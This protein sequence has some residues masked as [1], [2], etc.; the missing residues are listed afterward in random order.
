MTTKTILI[1]DYP[2]DLSREDC[3]DKVEIDEDDDLDD[4]VE[5]HAEEDDWS[6]GYEE[7]TYYVLDKSTGITTTH[8]VTVDFTPNFHSG[9]ERHTV[10]PPPPP[11]P[12]PRPFVPRAREMSEREKEARAAWARFN[13]PA[14]IPDDVRKQVVDHESWHWRDPEQ[15]LKDSM[16][17]PTTGF[18]R[19]PALG[20]VVWANA[21]GWL[22]VWPPAMCGR[23]IHMWNNI[24]RLV[25]DDGRVEC[26]SFGPSWD[27]NTELVSGVTDGGAE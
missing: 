7:R 16:N 13:W 11:S 19:R 20:A 2:E 27:R 24:A 12:P 23:F 1:A 4:A 3:C 10:R 8:T 18:D 14:W 25:L 5:A 17:P 21:R 22:G 15:W 6:D 9:T 26:V